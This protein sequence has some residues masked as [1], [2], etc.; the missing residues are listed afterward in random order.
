MYVCFQGHMK[1][2]SGGITNE[3]NASGVSQS[4]EKNHKDTIEANPQAPSGNRQ[5]DIENIMEKTSEKLALTEDTA[6]SADKQE[7]EDRV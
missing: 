1:T 6:G 5:E 3:L 2:H 7:S 4:S